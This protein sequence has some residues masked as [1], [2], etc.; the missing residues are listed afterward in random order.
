MVVLGIGVLA[1]AVVGCGGD[2][3]DSGGDDA[4]PTTTTEAPAEPLRI[5][6]TNDDGV[7]GQGI[8]DLVD[9]LA[10]LDDVVVT[11]VAPKDDKSGTGSQTTPPP[12][13]AA[14]TTLLGGADAVAVEG[15]P[16]D[17]VQYALDS[18]VGETPHLVVSG[19]NAGQN[20]GPVADQLSGTVGAARKAASNGIP[21]L[22][23]SQGFGAEFD[24][25]TGVELTLAW[26]EEHREA[27]LAGDVPADTV[28]NLNVPSCATGAV[29]GVIEVPTATDAGT[30]DFIAAPANCASTAEDPKD[31]I[32]AYLNG[33]APLAE[34]PVAPAG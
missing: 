25:A 17:S 5:L 21:A 3:D 26:I 15:F 27:L 11:V 33:F 4:E 32:D 2:D 18:V 9:G 19:I 13:V 16:A 34:V 8:S 23:V 31:D 12:L 24:Y 28:A 14:E 6:V 30:R 7:E 22:A 10:T 20:L 1:A 29:R